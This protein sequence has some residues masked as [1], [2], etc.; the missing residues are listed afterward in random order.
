M[1]KTN[2]QL[3]ELFGACRDKLN[4]V[5][6]KKVATPLAEAAGKTIVLSLT[7]GAALSAIWLNALINASKQVGEKKAESAPEQSASPSQAKEA[8]SSRAQHAA[9]SPSA[10]AS[11]FAA[12][13]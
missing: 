6:A 7:V 4:E 1:S 3:Q 13:G 9:A 11:G 8:S 12:V 10:T 2:E 5:D